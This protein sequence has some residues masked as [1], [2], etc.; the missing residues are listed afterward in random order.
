MAEPPFKAKAEPI[1][2]GSACEGSGGSRWEVRGEDKG[3]NSSAR[4]AVTKKK[5]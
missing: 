1:I 3:H 4:T 5:A 2:T